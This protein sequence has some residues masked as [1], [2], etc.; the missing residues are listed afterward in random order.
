MKIEKAAEEI[1][2]KFEKESWLINVVLVNTH[3]GNAIQVNYKW[4]PGLIF[5]KPGT[6]N[7]Y[8]IHWNCVR[9]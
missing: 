8:H 6:L 3:F 9:S 7:G 1:R 4:Q 5:N 2:K